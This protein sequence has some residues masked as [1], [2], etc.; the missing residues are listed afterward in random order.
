M[1][2]LVFSESCEKYTDL[3]RK[4]DIKRKGLDE[5]V[6]MQKMLQPEE[7][8]M[9]DDEFLTL[10][11]EGLYTKSKEADVWF[12]RCQMHKF[13]IFGDCRAANA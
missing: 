3:L 6:P 5:L 9:S 7:R 13:F 11:N 12:P 8:Q 1:D 2:S 4:E 10:A